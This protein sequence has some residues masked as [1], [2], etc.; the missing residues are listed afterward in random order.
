MNVLQLRRYVGV[1]CVSVFCAFYVDN[2][3]YKLSSRDWDLTSLNSSSNERMRVLVV[4]DPQLVGDVDEHWLF[5]AV[6]RMDSDWYLYNGYQH[7]LKLS[8]PDVVLYLGDLLDEGSKASNEQFD[9]YV[10]RFKS[11]FQTPSHIKQ[12]FIPGDNDIGG[13]GFEMIEDWK[14]ERFFKHFPTN[15]VTNVQ[16]VDFVTVKE[17]GRSIYVVKIE[18]QLIL[19]QS[20]EAIKVFISHLGALDHYH[21]LSHKLKPIDPNLVLAG[22]EHWASYIS[23]YKC[24]RKK[25]SRKVRRLFEDNDLRHNILDKSLIYQIVSPTSSYRMG[26][27]YSGYGLLDL[28]SSGNMKYR[29]LWLPRRYP[30]LYA[31]LVGGVVVACA[32]V[33]HIIFSVPTFRTKMDKGR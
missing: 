6:T 11:V 17:F 15:L 1:L 20:S 10:A 12:I 7:A 26:V 4:S 33:C 18:D 29:I 14:V 28:D 32:I 5:G 31:Y 30:L 21:Y 13:E 19:Q 23:C 22:H 24:W 27:K 25:S 8:Q 16:F 3:S 9:S 2:F